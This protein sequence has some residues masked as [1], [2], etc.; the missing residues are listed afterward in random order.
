M[1]H[2]KTTVE[3]VRIH[4]AFCI[5]TSC[6]FLSHF[7]Y[8]Y[9]NARLGRQSPIA[10]LVAL[11]NFASFLGVAT[12]L[13][14]ALMRSHG[15]L[16]RWARINGYQVVSNKMYPKNHPFRESSRMQVPFYVHLVDTGGKERHCWVL[17]G[18]MWYGS[19]VEQTEVHW[20]SDKKLLDEL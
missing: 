3:P 17:C 6:Y 16:A 11:V 13:S 12:I 14:G 18:H 4:V 5:L 2:G 8:Q 7:L 15:L 9:L 10:V 20:D 1:G 19:W